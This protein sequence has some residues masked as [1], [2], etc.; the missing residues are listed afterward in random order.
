MHDEPPIAMARDRE[1]ACRGM[2]L[3]GSVA[4]SSGVLVAAS[5]SVMTGAPVRALHLEAGS[6][7]GGRGSLRL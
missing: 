5:L 3:L 6:A 7:A 1:L 2:P 4:G